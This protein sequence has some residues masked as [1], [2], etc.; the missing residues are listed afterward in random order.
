M[1]TRKPRVT[2]G[3]SGQVPADAPHHIR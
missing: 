1:P 3:S 2:S